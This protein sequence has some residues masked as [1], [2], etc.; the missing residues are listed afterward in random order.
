MSVLSLANRGTSPS[1]RTQFEQVH[2]RSES[3]VQ[4]N[5]T[6]SRTSDDPEVA[7]LRD[8]QQRWEDIF[9]GI[10]NARRPIEGADRYCRR[11]SSHNPRGPKFSQTELDYQ[12]K[13]SKAAAITQ[14]S[15]EVE[16]KTLQPKLEAHQKKLCSIASVSYIN[17]PPE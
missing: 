6:S 9:D 15:L 1:Q 3:P 11:N 14:R 2:H 4:N 10:S 13:T 12:I 5:E 7:V 8:M 17:D 16:K